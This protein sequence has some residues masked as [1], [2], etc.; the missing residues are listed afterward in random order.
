MNDAF[1][2]LAN[3]CA[4]S[5]KLPCFTLVVMTLIVVGGLTTIVSALIRGLSR[6]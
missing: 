2:V 1:V 3:S 6:Q 4:V 5:F